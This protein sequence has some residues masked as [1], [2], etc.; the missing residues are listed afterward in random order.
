M[1]FPLSAIGYAAESLYTRAQAR[2]SSRSQTTRNAIWPGMASLPIARGSSGGH[3]RRAARHMIP[4]PRNRPSPSSSRFARDETAARRGDR[5]PQ[6]RDEG[7]QAAL[8]RGRRLD[9]SLRV[10]PRTRT[11]RPCH[12]PWPDQRRRQARAHA[13]GERARGDER[14]RLE[15][16]R[17]EANSMATPAIAYNVDGLRR[18]QASTTGSG[19]ATGRAGTSGGRGRVRPARRI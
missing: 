2:R 12:L 4:P 9:A 7:G 1:P 15:P 13:S 16:D 3:R 14:Q 8:D 19:R 5:V 17:D 11:G 6:F 18:Q 10:C